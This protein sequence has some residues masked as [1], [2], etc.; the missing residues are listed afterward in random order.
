MRRTFTRFLDAS[1]MT[2]G[3]SLGLMATACAATAASAAAV[4]PIA[5]PAISA[6]ESVSV[7]NMCGGLCTTA[8]VPHG[9]QN[10]GSAPTITQA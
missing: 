8:P 2:I 9:P 3:L 1:I 6:Y 7:Q 4:H 5:S 10:L